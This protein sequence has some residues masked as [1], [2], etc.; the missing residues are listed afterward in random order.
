MKFLEN[1]VFFKK[2]DEYIPLDITTRNNITKLPDQITNY[3][4]DSSGRYYKRTI[5]GS[6]YDL[7]NY[8]YK[9][10]KYIPI[11]SKAS[12]YELGSK[13]PIPLDFMIVIMINYQ[14]Y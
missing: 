6:K 13:S 3:K 5:V 2:G 9:D 1:I 4:L 8:V 11:E 10:K 14:N 7:G 12:V